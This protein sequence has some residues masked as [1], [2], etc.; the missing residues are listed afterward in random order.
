MDLLTE[1]SPETCVELRPRLRYLHSSSG[2]DGG[3]NQPSR[4]EWRPPDLLSALSFP[5]M[6][7]HGTCVRIGLSRVVEHHKTV[8]NSQSQPHNLGP[9][10]KQLALDV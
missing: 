4:A 7:A 5:R 9:N 8:V 1:N 10:T 2:G 6:P 3:P